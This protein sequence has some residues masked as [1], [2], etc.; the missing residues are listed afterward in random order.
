MNIL[1]LLEDYQRHYSCGDIIEI[2]KEDRAEFSTTVNIWKH[3]YTLFIEAHQTEGRMVLNFF[4]DI[5]VQTG[6]IIDAI[7]LCNY[8]NSQYTYSGKIVLLEDIEASFCY[9][10]LL[11]INNIENPSVSLIL[12]LIVDAGKFLARFNGILCDISYTPKTFEAIQKDIE[13]TGICG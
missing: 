5:K 11:D 12:M 9:K 4:P 2:I 8:L 13:N 1:E 10:V 7:M 6:K 3:N